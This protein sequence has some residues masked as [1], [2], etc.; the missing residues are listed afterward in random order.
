MLVDVT[1]LADIALIALLAGVLLLS[2]R[3]RASG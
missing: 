2:A 3:A 1:P